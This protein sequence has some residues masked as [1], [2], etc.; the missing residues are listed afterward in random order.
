MR[1]RETVGKSQ[2]QFIVML[3]L[4]VCSGLCVGLCYDT[5]APKRPDLKFEYKFV[6]TKDNCYQASR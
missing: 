1:R 6:Y 2:L 4:L 3:V 5:L